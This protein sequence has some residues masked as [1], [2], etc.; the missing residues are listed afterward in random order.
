MRRLV[1]SSQCPMAEHQMGFAEVIDGVAY[2]QVS[3]SLD[4]EERD[5]ENLGGS[6]PQLPVFSR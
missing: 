4:Y 5:H 1:K 6:D 2:V 3:N